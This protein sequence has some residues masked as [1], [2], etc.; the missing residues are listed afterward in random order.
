M[1]GAHD[2]WAAGG[3]EPFLRAVA[4]AIA[5]GSTFFLLTSLSLILPWT[6]DALPPVGRTSPILLALLMLTGRGYWPWAATA[7]LAGAATAGLLMQESPALT[8]ILTCTS[9]AEAYGCAWLLVRKMG[10]SPSMT[11]LPDL[12]WFATQEIPDLLRAGG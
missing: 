4:L 6:P 1:S 7:A 11:E 5:S 8:L 2:R 3:G 9:I 10:R 12:G